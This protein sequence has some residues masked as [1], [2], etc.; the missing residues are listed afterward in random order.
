MLDNQIIESARLIRNN[1]LNLNKELKVYE[2]DVKK[3]VDFLKEKISELELYKK[4]RLKQVKN[5]DD[6]GMA[7]NELLKQ[8][9]SIETEEIK[10]QKKIQKVNDRLEDLKK[11]EKVLFKIIKDRY[12]EMSESQILQEIQ[13][14]LSK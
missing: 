10:L 8:I 14:G 13:K 1:F 5:R 11:E 7:T 9:E 3:L 4:D 2:K 6:L 12:P